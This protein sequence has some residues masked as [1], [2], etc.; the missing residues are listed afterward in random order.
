MV[1]RDGRPLTDKPRKRVG[2]NALSNLAGYAFLTLIAV[3]CTPF[4]IRIIGEAR[5]GLLALVW[6]LF[7]YFGIFDFGLSRATANRLAKERSTATRAKV[8][9]T[10]LA[11]NLALGICGGLIFLLL[12]KQLLAFYIKIPDALSN[13]ID[14]GLPFVALLIPLATMN[15]VFVAALE[16]S[17]QF[18]KLNVLQV[19]GSA[20]FQVLPLLA[21]A[22]I[23]PRVDIAII[24]S[25]IGRAAAVLLT[26]IGAL[27]VIGLSHVFR[28]DRGIGG[29]LLRYG[30]WVAVFS[31]MAPLIVTIDQFI[32]GATIGVQAVA[33]YSIAYSVAGRANV[34]P[35]SL[36]RALFPRLSQH[37]PEQ[38]RTLT[39]NALAL[40]A[41]TTAGLY[42]AAIFLS[43]PALELW[44][45]K[46]FA[47]NA[48]PVM[49]ILFLGVWL[50][51]LAYAPFA[52][53]QAQGRPD[54]VAKISL[55][56]FLPY[57]AALWLLIA[58]FGLRGAAIA[59]ALRS[60]IDA[61]IQYKVAGLRLEGLG[62][63]AASIALMLTTLV[64]VQT[65]NAGLAVNLCLAAA[66]LALAA[67][68]MMRHP[69]LRS[70]V[71]N[72]LKALR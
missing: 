36:S 55:L 3:I 41:N 5:F 59:W 54:L 71:T 31:V 22:L 24:A 30:G 69:T 48:A 52:M 2:T 23:E 9:W 46:E 68:Q 19:I 43:R 60:G 18:F 10:A 33:Y 29:Q 20:I 4:F 21:V 64:V 44:L 42:A 63:L 65:A 39:T 62:T 53:T 16:A 6:L 38:A 12:S 58:S 28:F 8:F 14:R 1:T 57:L 40:L 34:I 15:G 49:E 27:R 7:G 51:G 66:C 67:F 35:Q 45:G 25:A 50:N 11:S 47:A 32:I 26:A 70:Y 56:E 37:T 13:E 61:I 17:E 72:T